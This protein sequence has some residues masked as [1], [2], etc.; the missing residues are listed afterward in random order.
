MRRWLERLYL[1]QYLLRVL[2]SNACFLSLIALTVYMTVSDSTGPDQRENL[3]RSSGR[4]VDAITVP[5]RFNSTSSLYYL[6]LVD[7]MILVSHS[8]GT[9]QGRIQSIALHVK[10]IEYGLSALTLGVTQVLIDIYFAVVPA[11]HRPP[12]SRIGFSMASLKSKWSYFD[13]YF[14]LLT[15]FALTVFQAIELGMVVNLGIAPR[16]MLSSVC[17]ALLLYRDDQ[18]LVSQLVGIFSMQSHL[19]YVKELLFMLALMRM[20]L[21]LG[22]H[23]RLG[24]LVA[25]MKA[26]FLEILSS[27]TILCSIYMIFASTAFVVLGQT[28]RE[29]SSFRL[30]LWTQYEMLLTKWP[31]ESLFNS[32]NSICAYLYIATFGVVLSLLVLNTF[33]AV[34]VSSFVKARETVNVLGVSGSFFS[35]LFRLLQE[36]ILSYRQGWPT[37]RELIEELNRS[38]E[39]SDGPRYASVLTYYRLTFPE[40]F[41]EVEPSKENTL[42]L[43]YQQLLE[44]EASEPRPRE[45]LMALREL[46]AALSSLRKARNRVEASSRSK[47]HREAPR[48]M[49]VRTSLDEHPPLDIPRTTRQ[50]RRDH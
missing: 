20:V 24:M 15:S 33:L 42:T 23:P 45:H 50:R 29:F 27:F 40:L 14:S 1:E 25:T 31:F 28:V 17:R 4:V 6:P 9:G 7:E 38:G 10:K 12:R 34:V 41:K 5:I 35:D 30:A 32:E 11:S 21:I 16:D 36:G 48:L 37:R 44:A 39:V 19:N 8:Q 2:W 46:R 49:T 13:N 3:L 26:G 47:S 18:L 22:A 43:L